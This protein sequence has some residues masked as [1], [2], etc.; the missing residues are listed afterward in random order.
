MAL[1]NRT[2]VVG[3]GL[4]GLGVARSLVSRE[5]QVTVLEKETL[6]GQHQ[7]GNNSGVLHA[8]LY[9]KPGS[10]KA[11]LAVAGI[12]QMTAF[13]REHGI[14]HEICG[15]I[16]LATNDAEVATL[17]SLYD[18][19]RQNGLRGLRY[20]SIDEAREIEPHV[21]GVAAIHVPEEGIVDYKAVSA[22]LAI[23]IGRRGGQ[24]ETGAE[25]TS[26]HHRAGQW[27]VET[28]CG[29]F[30]GS[31]LINCAG[32]HADRVARMA[33]QRPDC[34]IVPF[35]GEYFRL[36][37]QREYLVRNLVYPVPD[38]RFPFLG[39]HLTRLISGGIE[40]GPNAVLAMAREGYSRFTFKLQDIAA[41][42]LFPGL[43]RFLAR[44]PG[45]SWFE[46]RRSLDKQLFARSLQR[47]MPDI[48]A[49]DLV[50]GG[51]GVRAQAMDR[52]GGLIQDFRLL[53]SADALHV[54]NAPSPGATASLAIGDEIVR[55]VR[56]EARQAV[57]A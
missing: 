40:A 57:V 48:S 22:R 31:Y 20:L 15:K 24:V 47:L 30:T 53:H 39:V 36:R 55:L 27:V 4:I 49:D 6:V 3:G 29:E 52:D 14:A 38:P 35:R 21:T 33:G 50:A 19:G 45:V 11:K 51:S 10:L 44:Y 56:G 37:S 12:R 54:L 13:C 18:R 43:W 34:R 2:I 7:S 41:S 1:Q 8:G 26:I 5:A 17:R 28:S 9:Y 32:L 23:E 16:V 42:I 25:V 46:L